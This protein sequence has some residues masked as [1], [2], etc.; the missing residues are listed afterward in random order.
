MQSFITSDPAASVR[1]CP[2]T[3]NTVLVYLPFMRVAGGGKRWRPSDGDQARMRRR[4]DA[5]HSFIPRGAYL[6]APER[7]PCQRFFSDHAAAAMHFRLHGAK[8]GSA[9]PNTE[10]V[11][12]DLQE[13]PDPALQNLQINHTPLPLH[14]IRRWPHIRPWRRRPRSLRHWRGLR[15]IRADL[16]GHRVRARPPARQGHRE[17]RRGPCPAPIS[18]R[19]CSSWNLAMRYPM[20]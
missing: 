19:R 3:W 10:R 2:A 9:R 20:R 5:L 4:I 8:R 12:C 13:S 17:G 18:C 6:P 11:I 7:A 16:P 15:P 1:S 14:R